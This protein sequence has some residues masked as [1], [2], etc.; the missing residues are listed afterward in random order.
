MIVTAS[1]YFREIFSEAVALGINPSKIISQNVVMLPNFT[2]QK[3]K[4]LRES[5]LSII[6]QNC[7]GGF[8]YHRFHL[9]FLSPTTTCLELQCGHST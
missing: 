6:S 3:Y 9:P 4:I 5:K 8:L 1:R 7:F 2:F